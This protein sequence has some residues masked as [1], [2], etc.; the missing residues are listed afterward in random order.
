MNAFALSSL[1]I[2]IF[3]TAIG[4]FVYCRG[5]DN[6]AA[7]VFSFFCF[8]TIIWAFGGYKVATTTS[9]KIAFFWWQIAFIGVIL[10][11]V[12]YA[13]FIFV[14]L[15]TNNKRLIFLIY[16]FATIFIAIDLFAASSFL[17]SLKFV[18]NQFYWVYWNQY[19]SISYL[20]FYISFYWLLIIYF[21]SL[22]VK[23]F[24]KSIGFRRGQ[25]KY[26][27]LSAALGWFGAH[28]N[29]LPVFGINV[30]PYLNYFIVIWAVVIAYIILRHKFL[31][32][33]A[34]IKAKGKSLRGLGTLQS[35]SLSL[36]P[37]IKSIAKVYPNPTHTP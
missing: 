8:V 18:F 36:I 33:E 32:I 27:L 12:V 28:C 17:G 37:D 21:F 23:E 25:L 11:P 30:Y 20:L 24:I 29:F 2:L 15:N 7:K 4:I 5:K 1:L 19:K 34:I 14:F 9:Y 22:L 3:C 26:L 13:H 31:N 16:L 35:S 10:C 6:K